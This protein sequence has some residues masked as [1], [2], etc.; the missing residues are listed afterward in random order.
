MGDEWDRL[1]T[2]I[3]DLRGELQTLSTRI[4]L[5]TDQLATM[6]KLVERLETEVQETARWRA[7]F[8]ERVEASNIAIQ[9]Q[10]NVVTNSIGAQNRERKDN[11]DALAEKI[12]VVA[13]G[14]T[15]LQTRVAIYTG[16]AVFIA[17][18]G[19]ELVMAMVK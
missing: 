4:G 16:I 15:A 2:K 19:K 1:A 18:F 11:H 12:E 14:L 6:E 7:G 10:L 9:R 13:T 8:V 17:T 3:H 5:H